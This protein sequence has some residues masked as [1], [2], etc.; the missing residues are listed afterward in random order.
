M[1][2]LNIGLEADD[3][4]IQASDEADQS[5]EQPENTNEGEGNTDTPGEGNGGEGEESNPEEVDLNPN[6]AGE[7]AKAVE[8][9]DSTEPAKVLQ[10][11]NYKEELAK[12]QAQK[13]N[14]D[15]DN[16]DSDGGSD[17]SGDSDDGG[18]LDDTDGDPAEGENNSDG[19]DDNGD[20][21]SGEDDGEGEKDSEGDDGSSD[22]EVAQ[23]AYFNEGF[24][25]ADIAMQAMTVMGR[26]A[27]LLRKRSELGGISQHTAKI[28]KMSMEDYSLKVG[29]DLHKH[30]NFALEDF[31]TYTGSAKSTKELT[32]SVEGFIDDVWQAIKTFM[33]RFWAWIDATFFSPKN[34][35]SSSGGG[36]GGGSAA[37]K[38]ARDRT[39]ERQADAIKRLDE[40]FRQEQRLRN[41][42]EQRGIDKEKERLRREQAAAEQQLSEKI[43]NTIFRKNSQATYAEM[44]KTATLW[45]DLVSA[46][47]AFFKTVENNAAAS[48]K[49]LDRGDT[50]LTE[51]FLIKKESLA[52]RFRNESNGRTAATRVAVSDEISGGNCIELTK[53]VPFKMSGMQDKVAYLRGLADQGITMGVATGK[54]NPP[55]NLP[56]L[57]AE[58][59]NDFKKTAV[60]LQKAFGALDQADATLETF[61]KYGEGL[62]NENE[63]PKNWQS[64]A[65]DHDRINLL[66]ASVLAVT[67]NLGNV[68]AGHA[69][70]KTQIGY[71]ADTVTQMAVK[72]SA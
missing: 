6:E 65:D 66:R 52:I 68:I 49:L 43:A 70:I 37:T 41:N 57:E 71:Y 59:L 32:I 62:A 16:A 15:D 10:V 60:D 33:R 4:A 67:K 11:A 23:E 69:K 14:E 26:H 46:L 17:D 31:A 45:A 51:S 22:E 29:V 44:Q 39:I 30:A 42:D 8:N 2:F 25:Q 27:T 24:R 36:G 54:G 7:A 38:D 56:S 55:R 63:T 18:E 12:L 47:P 64:F 19:E 20:D 1:K 72:R 50:I 3:E 21:D 13:E 58:H 48:F 9:Q 61:R 28:I 53:G 40:K 34:N 35:G 5:T